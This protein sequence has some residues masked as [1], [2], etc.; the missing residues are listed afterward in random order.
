M[1]TPSDVLMQDL[2]G[3]WTLSKTLS[4]PFDRVFAIQGIP[5][6]IRKVV[7]IATLSLKATQQVDES[8][9]KTLVFTQA[10]SVAIGGLSEENEVRVLD[11][12]EEFHSSTLFGTSSHR[13]RLTNGWVMEQIWGFSMLND[14]RWL[15]RTMVVRKGNEVAT[16]RAIYDWKGKEDG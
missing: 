2:T 9:T 7:S 16:A 6:I 1:A 5:W 3:S 4:D 15:M 11:W 12:R 10:A 14:E 13:S 8:G